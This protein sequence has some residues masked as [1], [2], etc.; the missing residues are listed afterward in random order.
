[1]VAR[2]VGPGA[3]LGACCQFGAILH[4]A[5]AARQAQLREV[6]EGIGLLFQIRDDLLSVESTEA[7]AGKTLTTDA[8]RGKNTFVSRLGL[9]ATRQAGSQLLA[10]LETRIAALDLAQPVVLLEMARQAF[11]RHWKRFPIRSAA[12]WPALTRSSPSPGPPQPPGSTPLGP[13]QTKSRRSKR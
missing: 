13:V 1:M 5:D 11:A 4:G 10:E 12:S 8:E 7:A 6:G 2:L 3:L 9:A